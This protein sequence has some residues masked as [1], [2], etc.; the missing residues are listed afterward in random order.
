METMLDRGYGNC[1]LRR[2]SVATVV[3]DL[4]LAQDGSAYHLRAW[5]I[6]PNHVHVLAK[7]GEIKTMEEI[8]EE[9]KGISSQEINRILGR[10]GQVWHPDYF[11]RYMRDAEHYENTRRYI[12]MNPVKAGLVKNPNAWEWSWVKR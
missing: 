4:L 8:V 11:D 1:W 6:M 3:R 10:T 9:W 5:V 2:R 7:M 12:I